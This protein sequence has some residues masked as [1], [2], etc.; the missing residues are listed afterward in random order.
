MKMASDW[1][2]IVWICGIGGLIVLWARWALACQERYRDQ[3]KRE[4][5]KRGPV[6]VEEW[7]AWR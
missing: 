6:G 3:L 4:R 2:G 5:L 1:I 7:E